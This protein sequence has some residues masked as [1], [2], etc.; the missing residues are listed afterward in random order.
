M[1]FSEP[2]KVADPNNFYL[3]SDPQV[4]FVFG[5]GFCGLT[6]YFDINHSKVS[7]LLPNM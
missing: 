6:E 3:D 4:F 7:F 2:M 1:D 5:Y